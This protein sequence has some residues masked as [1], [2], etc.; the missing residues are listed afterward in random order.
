MTSPH[1]GQRQSTQKSHWI[2]QSRSDPINVAH[3][4]LKCQILIPLT[5]RPAISM[6]R[7]FWDKCTRWPQMTLDTK[8]SKMPHTCPTSTFS[9]FF[10]STV[11]RFW[12]TCHFETSG[13]NDPKMTLNI[14]GPKVPHIYLL[15]LYY[16]KFPSVSFYGQP[17]TIYR[18]F[19]EKCTEIPQITS[20]TKR[21]G[22]PFIYVISTPESQ[23]SPLFPRWSLNFQTFKFLRGSVYGNLMHLE[24]LEEILKNRILK[25]SQIYSNTFVR[26]TNN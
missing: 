18:P 3:V 26:T 4:P 16:Y 7:Q 12:V 6:Y 14:K 22:V 5:L 1:P 21:W 19:W 9:I 13:R 10:C 17:F 24:F 25:T 2:L 15:V 20:N 8:R 23:I 11:I